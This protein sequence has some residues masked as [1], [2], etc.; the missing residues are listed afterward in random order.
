MPAANIRRKNIMCLLS[1][2]SICEDT[3]AKLE[4]AYALVFKSSLF[5]GE[6]VACRK[7]SPLIIGIKAEKLSWDSIY[8]EGRYVAFI[9]S[10]GPLFPA[11][12]TVKK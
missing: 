6:L 11:L 2:R 3:V 9:Q 12:K 1:S 7:G 10:I 4:G 5:P 8:V